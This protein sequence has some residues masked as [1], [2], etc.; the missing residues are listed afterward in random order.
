MTSVMHVISGLDM[1]GAETTLVQVARELCR[2]GHPQYV[3]S[4][5]TE[6]MYANVLRESGVEVSALGMSGILNVPRAL[7][8]LSRLLQRHKPVAIQGWM[9]HGNILAALAHRLASGRATRS[10]LWNLRA[11]NM[12]SARYGGLL[13]LSSAVSKWP[14]IVIANSQAGETFHAELGYRPRRSQIIA[15]GID[16]Q[17]FTL[18]RPLRTQLRAEFGIPQD[19]IVVIHPARVDPMKGHETFIEAMRMVPD[20]FAVMV[21]ARTETLKVPSNVRVLGLR[22]DVE[23]LYSLADIVASTSAFGE[24]FSNVL[25]E[26]MSCGLVPIATDVGDARRIVGNCGYV[27]PPGDAEALVRAM[28]LVASLT[29]AE[30]EAMGV[31]VRNHIVERFDLNRAVSEYEQLYLSLASAIAAH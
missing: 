25:A 6:G 30:R 31:Q 3:V 10:L 20:M 7:L 19:A 26:G 12:D 13:R 21:G 16:T 11:S 15:N 22:R 4:L 23:R 17:K 8:K 29:S 1:G 27:I 9:Y 5:R 18:N 28:N 2:R 14:D 24:G